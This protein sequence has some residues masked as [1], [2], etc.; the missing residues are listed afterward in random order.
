[1]RHRIQ[2]QCI[3]DHCALVLQAFKMGRTACM[4]SGILS[5]NSA[6]PRSGTPFSGSAGSPRFILFSC[7]VVPPTSLAA[8]KDMFEPRGGPAVHSYYHVLPSETPNTIKRHT[9]VFTDP[10]GCVS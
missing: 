7:P 1:M 9:P 4:T 6:S 3:A 10:N 8:T 5:D 2:T